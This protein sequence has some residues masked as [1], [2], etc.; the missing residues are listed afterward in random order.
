M[1][2]VLVEHGHE[3]V[4][5]R[6]AV[7]RIVER[8]AELHEQPRAA[9]GSLLA[10]LALGA[11]I[12]RLAHEQHGVARSPQH[13]I[14]IGQP[15]KQQRRRRRT[16]RRRA[17]RVAGT[18]EEGSR[19]LEALTA[20]LDLGQPRERGAVVRIERNHRLIRGRRRAQ[21]FRLEG[22]LALCD[23]RL[24]RRR[25]RR[26]RRRSRRGRHR[27]CRDHDH[28]H[29]RHPRRGHPPPCAARPRGRGSHPRRRRCAP[30]P[31]SRAPAACARSARARRP[32][33]RRRARPVRPRI[34]HLRRPPRAGS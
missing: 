29:P 13:N 1:L 19:R 8:A 18:L 4:G 34:C 24:G 15:R 21:P 11:E 20:H 16:Q 2:L 28:R 26:R 25:R 17:R 27:R 12:K 5:A 14:R 10:A 3:Q 23:K 33:A 9:R 31:A 30:P 32:C 22:G 6:L 7:A